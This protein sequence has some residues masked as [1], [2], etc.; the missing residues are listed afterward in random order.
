MCDL[1][2]LYQNKWTRCTRKEEGGMYLIDLYFTLG[3]V[4]YNQLPA[5]SISF[6]CYLYR[7]P[8]LGCPWF[9]RYTVQKYSSAPPLFN[10]YNCTSMPFVKHVNSL[11]FF[12]AHC[13]LASSPVIYCN[14]LLKRSV[15][16]LYT[17]RHICVIHVM[18]TLPC[19]SQYP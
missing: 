15:S 1:I 14:R 17:L 2:K 13:M 5:S 3:V 12:L 16:I 10:C 6:P 9:P 4:Y 18:I 7:I 8:S 11:L 19:L